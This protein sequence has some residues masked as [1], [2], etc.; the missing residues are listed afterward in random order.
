[1]F[2]RL[3]LALVGV[4]APTPNSVVLRDSAIINP[5]ELADLLQRGAVG[6]IALRFFDRQGR[7]VR[8]EM[9]ERIIGIR[10][11]QLQ[12]VPRVVGVSGGPEKFAALHGA[13]HGKLI[14]VLITDSLSAQKLLDSDRQEGDPR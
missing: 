11:E 8:G 2:S 4:G 12:R 13:L 10:L 7:P 3:D 9:D 6:D 1:M 5:A 14:N